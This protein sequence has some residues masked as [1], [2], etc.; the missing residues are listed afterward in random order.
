[1]RRIGGAA[2]AVA[3]RITIR[4]VAHAGIG[5]VA[6]AVGELEGIDAVVAAT[7]EVHNGWLVLPVELG[8]V[9]AREQAI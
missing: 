9:S 5:L 1:M 8:Q 4:L 7:R 2:A 3:L 6:D